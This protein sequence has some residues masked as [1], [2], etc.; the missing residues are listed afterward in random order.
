MV[1][2]VVGRRMCPLEAAGDRYALD[3][4]IKQMTFVC[5]KHFA[6]LDAYLELFFIFFNFSPKAK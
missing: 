5:D 3:G 4:S 2:L 6:D 1:K